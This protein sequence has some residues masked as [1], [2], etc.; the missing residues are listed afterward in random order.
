MGTLK[1]QLKREYGEPQDVWIRNGDQSSSWQR[2]E[3][4]IDMNNYFYQVKSIFD[5]DLTFSYPACY[6]SSITK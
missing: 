2:A 3:I 4:D 5:I 1:V 6:M